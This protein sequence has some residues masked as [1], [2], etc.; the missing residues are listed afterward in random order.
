MLR[1]KE[2]ILEIVASVT[3]YAAKCNLILS[4]KIEVI[5]IDIK[6]MK[7]ISGNL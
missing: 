4:T 3:D 7:I 6:Q 5:S 1:K 2:D